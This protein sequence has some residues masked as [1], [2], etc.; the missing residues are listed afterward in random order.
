MAVEGMPFVLLRP[1]RELLRKEGQGCVKVLK[2][3][4]WASPVGWVVEDFNST[5]KALFGGSF[6]SKPEQLRFF[7]LY[8]FWCEVFEILKVV[9]AVQPPPPS[10]FRFLSQYSG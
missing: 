5:R 1:Y 2:T 8:R 9:G 6:L 4:A 10:K 3:L 7:W